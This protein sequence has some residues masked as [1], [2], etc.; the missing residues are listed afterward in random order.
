MD[1]DSYLNIRRRREM[2]IVE[3]VMD[4]LFGLHLIRFR[5]LWVGSENREQVLVLP[6]LNI[7]VLGIHAVNETLDRVPFVANHKSDGVSSETKRAASVALHDRIQVSP[8]HR[9]D[10][11][12]GQLK[13]AVADK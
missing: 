3:K 13:G 1:A 7:V 11:L 9:A 6:F 4:F 5:F 12:G 2:L 10:L 8:D